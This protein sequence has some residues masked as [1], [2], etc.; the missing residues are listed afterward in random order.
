MLAAA[1][2]WDSGLFRPV[3]ASSCREPPFT[4]ETTQ[5]SVICLGC[6]RER[7]QIILWATCKSINGYF[8]FKQVTHC[9][10]KIEVHQR[11][12]EMSET[13]SEESSVHGESN[14]WSPFL[15][16]FNHIEMDDLAR[17]V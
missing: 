12:S 10:A 9:L 4:V 5:E 13:V 17:D 16:L 6:Q 11:T 2:V 7:F 14:L 1:V 15:N 3:R 8:R